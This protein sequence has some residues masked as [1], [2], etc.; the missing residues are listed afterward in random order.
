MANEVTATDVIAR[1]LPV[2]TAPTDT[3][4]IDTLIEDLLDDARVRIHDFDNRVSD[5]RLRPATLKRIT[6]QAVIRIWKTAFDPR[7]SYSETA[8]PYS[9]SGSMA[10]DTEARSISFTDAEIKTL[11]GDLFETNKALKLELAPHARSEDN[12]LWEPVS[13]G[14]GHYIYPTTAWVDGVRYDRT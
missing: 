10:S 9:Q 8:G 1:W 2:G 11:A 6:A 13:T 12:W 7:T 3:T 5:G 4:R 14:G